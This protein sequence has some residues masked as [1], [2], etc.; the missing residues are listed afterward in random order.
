M[1]VGR[2]WVLEGPTFPW[3]LVV[4][5]HQ[6]PA[7]RGSS[8][9]KGLG[10]A[11]SQPTLSSCHHQGV[12]VGLSP[13]FRRRRIWRQELCVNPEGYGSLKPLRPELC[14]HPVPTSPR[15]H[16]GL[17]DGAGAAGMC[18]MGNCFLAVPQMKPGGCCHPTW[19]VTHPRTACT[20]AVSSTS[21][22]HTGYLCP[23]GSLT[24]TRWEQGDSCPQNSSC[25]RAAGSPS[26]Q[27][28][29]ARCS[30]AGTKAQSRLSKCGPSPGHIP[31]LSFPLLAGS[32]CC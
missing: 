25:P 10:L 3:L 19:S 12:Q 32:G 30:V 31:W 8:T 4:Q 28:T 5:V 13:Q 26:L 14:F 7:G 29:P 11:G 2:G 9:G 21:S 6:A 16:C 20:I 23:T 15:A 27:W 24:A 18:S 17:T 1:P 22:W